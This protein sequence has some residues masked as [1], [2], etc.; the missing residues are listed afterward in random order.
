MG[1]NLKNKKLKIITLPNPILREKSK[2]V[3][4][5]NQEVLS[6]IDE[7][8]NLLKS[9]KEPQGLG[10]SAVQV[11]HLKQIF[12]A[13]IGKSILPFIN[14]KILQFSEEKIAFLEGCLSIPDFY[15]HVIR[16]TDIKLQYQNDKG[17]L[18]IQDY[19]GLAARIIQHEVDHLNGIL[20]IDH[21]HSQNQKLYKF[22]GKD[23]KGQDKFVEVILA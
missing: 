9:N 21:V 23:E 15:G 17:K 2:P 8:I 5:I 16:P 22:L 7:M 6:L 4:T 19:H 12:V 1:K 11:G 10:L 18:L 13:K 14:P 3:S 20:F